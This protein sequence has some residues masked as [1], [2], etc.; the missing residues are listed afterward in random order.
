MV[1]VVVAEVVEEEEEE[2]EEEEVEVEV[3]V[4]VEVHI[5]T[6]TVA[7]AVHG[8]WREHTSSHYQQCMKFSFPSLRREQPPSLWMHWAKKVSVCVC[9]LDLALFVVSTSN[10]Q[11]AQDWAK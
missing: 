2:E 5:V 7:V 8:I 1:V 10:L 3:N 9:L 4:K 6:A 11:R